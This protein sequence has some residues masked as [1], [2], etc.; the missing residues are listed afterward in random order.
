LPNFISD[1]LIVPELV[2][3]DINSDNIVREISFLNKNKKSIL[4]SYDL[5][6]NNIAKSK[7]VF[8]NVSK[9]VLSNEIS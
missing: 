5:V 7:N 3:S 1:Q 9:S 4:N 6:R 2:Q 8:E